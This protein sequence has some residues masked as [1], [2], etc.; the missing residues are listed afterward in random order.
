MD[1]LD[2]SW[3]TF[4]RTITVPAVIALCALIAAT[5][6]SFVAVRTYRRSRPKLK[7]EP[8]LERMT[9]AN[10]EVDKLPGIGRSA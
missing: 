10:F 8:I 9:H 3:L 5:I 6:S 1:W 4:D 7:I 2:L